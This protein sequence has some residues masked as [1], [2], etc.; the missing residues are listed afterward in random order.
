[1]SGREAVDGERGRMILISSPQTGNIRLLRKKKL[2]SKKQGPRKQ[3]S[4]HVLQNGRDRHN[5]LSASH[6]WER[7]KRL[8]AVVASYS[9]K[10]Q[11]G[12]MMISR[13]SFPLQVR[14][15]CCCCCGSSICW[16][17]GRW[18]Y[19]GC[20]EEHVFRVARK[21]ANSDGTRDMG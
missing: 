12:G 18:N 15:R 16:C 14:E 1:M 4:T 11:P 13:E 10:A 7:R 20:G 19:G 2:L 9:L 21:R 6:R 8:P 5:A 3:K 17:W